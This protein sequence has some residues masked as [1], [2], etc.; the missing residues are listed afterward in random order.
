MPA[1]RASITSRFRWF[2]HPSAIWLRHE[3]PVHKKRI[4]VFFCI[5][6]NTLF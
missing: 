1:D 5:F 6:L 4:L 3:F 2:A